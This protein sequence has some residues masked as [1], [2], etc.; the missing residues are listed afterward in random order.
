[1]EKV[2]SRNYEVDYYEKEE[3]IWVVNTHLKDDE[4]D[5]EATVEIN[6]SEMTVTDAKIKF[7]NFPL[8]HCFLI[9]DKAHQMKGLKIDN[10]FSRNIMKIF[11]GPQGCPNIMSLFNVSIP[12]I[13]YYYYPQKIRTGKME[14]AQWDNMIRTELKNACL[15]H[16]LL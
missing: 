15:A 5:I 13:I 14:Y 6:M 8:E 1:M 16:T 7:N 10:E 2:T 12:G 11:M 4:H 3:E 9:E